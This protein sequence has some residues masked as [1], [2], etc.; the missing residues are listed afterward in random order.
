[1]VKQICHAVEYMHDND[2]IHRDL[3]P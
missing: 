3:K 2:I 1:M